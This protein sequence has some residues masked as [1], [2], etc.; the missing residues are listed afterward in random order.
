[1]DG[2]LQNCSSTYSIVLMV[3]LARLLMPED[4]GLVG[5]IVV[6]TGFAGIFSDAGFGAALIQKKAVEERHLSSVFW[7]GMIVGALLSVITICGAPSIAV[8]YD[9]PLLK[10]L[11][12]LIALNFV[13]VSLTI[14]PSALLR[15]SMSFKR[16]TFVNIIAMVVSGG[17]AIVL[18]LS[19]LGVW[20]LIWRALLSS[21][22][23]VLCLWI[24]TEWRPR[25][26]F[27]GKALRELLNF[28]GNLV[29]SSTF[30]YWVRNADNC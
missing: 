2:N 6:F 8:F 25:F 22:V 24:L 3:I 10:P 26:T 27:Q 5:M 29:G 20:T 13:L 28:S 14:V 17:A 7:L 16:L 18:A 4:F 1:M 19:G 21:A 23:T 11:A 12:S 15:R 9:E 30:N